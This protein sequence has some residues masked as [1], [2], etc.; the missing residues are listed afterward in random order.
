MIKKLLPTLIGPVVLGLFSIACTAIAQQTGPTE[1]KGVAGKALGA[2]DLGPEID[3]MAGREL[4]IRYVT[5]EPGGVTAAHNHKDRPCVEYIVQGHV[6]EFRNGVP[7]EHGPGEYVL[8]T[9][10]TTH[11]WENKGPSQVVLLPV[12]IVKTSK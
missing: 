11:W 1:N 12:D 5:I 4:R 9:K 2:V 7:I 10:E 6:I 3:G 8:A